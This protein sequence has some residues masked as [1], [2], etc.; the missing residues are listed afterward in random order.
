MGSRESSNSTSTRNVFL[1]TTR[2]KSSIFNTSYKSGDHAHKGISRFKYEQEFTDYDMIGEDGEDG[3]EEGEEAE[4]AAEAADGDEGAEDGDNDVSSNNLTFFSHKKHKAS[5][6]IAAGTGLTRSAGRLN[7]SLGTTKLQ[8]PDRSGLAHIS[9]EEP[10]I[11]ECMTNWSPFKKNP[12][13][14][15]VN[16]LK[17]SAS[18]SDLSPFVKDF[19]TLRKWMHKPRE[20]EDVLCAHAAATSS[21]L[22]PPVTTSPSTSTY[23]AAATTATAAAPNHHTKL[24][25]MEGATSHRASFIQAKPDP[26]AFASSGLVS[27]T[28]SNLFSNKLTIPDTPVKKSP[29]SRSANTTSIMDSLVQPHTTAGSSIVDDKLFHSPPLFSAAFPPIDTSPLSG[30]SK[31]RYRHPNSTTTSL[32]SS[33]LKRSRASKILSNTELTHTLQQFTDD[34]YGSDEDEESF[35]L[36]EAAVTPMISVDPSSP[37]QTPTKTGVGKPLKSPFFLSKSGRTINAK[38]EGAATEL[39]TNPDAHLF[40]KFLNVSPIGTGQFSQVYQVTFGPAN[41]RYAVKS[42]QPKKYNSRKRILQEIELLSEISETTLDQEG[43]EYVVAYI[44]SWKHQGAYYVMTEYCEN[45]SLDGFLREQ[46]IAKNTRL[47]DWRVWKIIVELSLALRFI[48][49][50]CRVVHLDLKPANVLITF[51]GTLKLADFGMAAKLPISEEGFENEGDR[52]YIAPEIIADGVYDFR[53]DIFSLGLMIV[54][55]AANV[56]LPDNGNAW[57]KLRSGDLSDAGGLSSTDLHSASLFSATNANTETTDISAA[58]SAGAK[59]RGARNKIPAW[60]PKFLIDGE[61]LERIVRWM[62]EPD[63]TKRPTANDILHT[64]E[65]EYVEM[66]RKAGAV[67]QEDDFGPKPEFFV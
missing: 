10:T 2:P 42:I 58:T 24:R 15:E 21:T 59:N 13:T 7:L 11:N 14:P 46:V 32:S 39:A 53:A 65:C 60:V 26:S 64:E 66:T 50:S 56:V 36:A 19:G 41:T 20:N 44:S 30:A 29:L 57:H 55:I 9:E 38:V 6:G 40:A 34:L 45:G 61:S 43:K 8:S 54:E 48:H 5:Q 37:L 28:R 17:R 18:K 22:A 12:A 3:D 23:I 35:F 51:E 31:H 25:K 4:E 67:I 52:E 16:N 1:N 49:D 63:Y 62:I 27:K 33:K 47:E